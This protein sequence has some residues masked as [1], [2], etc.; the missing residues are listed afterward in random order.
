[1]SKN[2]LFVLALVLGL[3]AAAQAQSTNHPFGL[4]FFAGNG[5]LGFTGKYFLSHDDGIQATLGWRS[6]YYYDGPGPTITVDWV[7]RL[8]R[9]IPGSGVVQFGFDFGVGG[10]LGYVSDGCYVNLAGNR[11]CYNNTA[12]LAV[13]VPVVFSAYWPK[14]RIEAYAEVAPAFVLAPYRG[15]A[16]MGGVGGRFYF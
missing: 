10:A 8:A 9:I 12:D 11:T 1:M 14:A 7:H 4:G 6:S 2:S 16:V 5:N 15:P 13:R 3:P